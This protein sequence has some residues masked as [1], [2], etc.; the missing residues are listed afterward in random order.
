MILKKEYSDLENIV[1]G[2][3]KDKIF[4]ARGIK[5]MLDSVKAFDK[6]DAII[7]K[8]AEGTTIKVEES[9]LRRAYS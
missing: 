8:I 4:D 6:I 5:R 9:E 1:K 3:M 7:S 2:W